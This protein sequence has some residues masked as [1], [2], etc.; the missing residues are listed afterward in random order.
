MMLTSF[1]AGQSALS[2]MDDAIPQRWMR[3]L[4]RAEDH[5]HFIEAVELAFKG[6]LVRGEAL[7]QHLKGLMIHR[8]RLRKIERVVR[9]LERRH[10]A[11]DAELQA[12]AAHLIEHADFFDEPQRMIKG[13][14]IDHRAKAQLRGALRQRR[15]KHAGRCRGADRRAVVL[16][17][18]VRVKPRAVVSLGKSQA[19]G[20]KSPSDTPASSR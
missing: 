5:R 17:E 18:V 11:A 13:Q 8:L 4:H 16:G 14:Q 20:E 2:G 12:P 19:I 10:A 6:Q 15:K 1:S 7:E 9:G 3:A